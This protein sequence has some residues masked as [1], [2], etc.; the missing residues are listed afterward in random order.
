[1]PEKTGADGPFALVLK[2]DNVERRS[3]VRIPPP[4]L[5]IPGLADIW[6]SLGR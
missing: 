6:Q 1:M 2:T 5:G 3:Q 4:P